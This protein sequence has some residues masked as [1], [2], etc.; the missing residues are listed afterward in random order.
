MPGAE[1]SNPAGLRL[2][3]SIADTRRLHEWLDR[4]VASGTVPESMDHAIRLCLEE[5]VMNIVLHGYGADEPGRI[6]V[7]LWRAGDRV[8]VRLV[9]GAPP[10]DPTLAQPPIRLG[11]ETG[12]GAGLKLMRRFAASLA[13]ER[14]AGQ[15]RL[16]MGFN[17]APARA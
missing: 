1:L 13:Y 17:P 11:P 16:T 10:F 15:N 7:A 5:A 6:E 12:G 3:S 9:D 2:V 14:A 8:M 4:L